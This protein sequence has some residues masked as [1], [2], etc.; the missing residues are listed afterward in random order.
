MNL[1]SKRRIKEHRGK[2]MEVYRSHIIYKV[3][4][5]TLEWSPN[6]H[7]YRTDWINNREYIYRIGKAG[8][9]YQITNLLNAH[10]ATIDEAQTLIDDMLDNG[11]IQLTIKEYQ[12]WVKRPNRENNWC[13]SKQDLQE[14]LEAYKRAKPRKRYG[15]EQ[16]LTDA[17]FHSF[18]GLLI[19]GKFN[20]AK[21]WIEKEFLK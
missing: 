4:V 18:C 6:D 15:Y 1:F 10:T 5:D 21:Q 19:E 16:R 11:T 14:T 20:E 8:R 12:E 9:G 2:D 13:F 7:A 3:R 17:N